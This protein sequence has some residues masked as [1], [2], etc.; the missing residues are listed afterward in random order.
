MLVVA[1]EDPERSVLP[2]ACS[3]DRGRSD[4]LLEQGQVGEIRGVVDDE[5]ERTVV[6]ALGFPVAAR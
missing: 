1:D 5:R 3:R 4:A 6:N 2:D